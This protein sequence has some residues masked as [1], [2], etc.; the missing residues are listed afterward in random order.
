[1]VNPARG[2]VGL[3]VDGVERRMRLTLG[4]LAELEERLKAGS[5]VALAERFESGQ[6]AAV[7][8]IALLAAGLR[9]AGEAV[10]EEALARAEIG[11]GALGALRAG[12]ALMARSFGAGAEGG[13]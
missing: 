13:A 10:D 3:V 11:G 9:G 2:E 7:D 1:M 8:L 12:V 6:V 5:L 4:A